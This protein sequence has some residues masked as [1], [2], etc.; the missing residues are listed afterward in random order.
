MRDL[1][2]RE[3]RRDGGVEKWLSQDQRGLCTHKAA[4]DRKRWRKGGWPE[5][6]M[7]QERLSKR[8]TNLSHV[9]HYLAARVPKPSRA[10]ALAFSL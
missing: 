2:G 10:A 1:P 5:R 4:K 7:E 3:E 8:G 6:R 9:S